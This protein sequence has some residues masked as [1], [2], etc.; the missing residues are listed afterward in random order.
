MMCVG[1]KL[2]KKIKIMYA[3]D[4]ACERVSGSIVV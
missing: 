1:G 3:N 4:L 2:F